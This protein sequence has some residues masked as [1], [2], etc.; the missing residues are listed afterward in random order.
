M[1]ETVIQFLKRFQT[2]RVTA[3]E[4]KKDIRSSRTQTLGYNLDYSSFYS[5]IWGNRGQFESYDEIGRELS[6][7]M[8]AKSGALPFIPIITSLTFWEIIDTVK[9]RIDRVNEYPFSDRKDFIFN[10]LSEIEE[11]LKSKGSVYLGRSEGSSQIFAAEISKLRAIAGSGIEKNIEK[12]EQ[13]IG[14]GGPVK[15]V[16]DI[17]PTAND[18]PPMR[19][20]DVNNLFEKMWRERTSKDRRDSG[21]KR[22]RYLVD[23]MNI[24]FSKRIT[25]LDDIDIDYVTKA[26]RKASFCPDV[27]RSPLVPY[28][29]MQACTLP[30]LR[31]E[32]EVLEFFDWMQSDCSRIIKA[33]ERRQQIDLEDM[34]LPLRMESFERD[35]YD[36]LHHAKFA[37]SQELHDQVSTFRNFLNSKDAEESVRNDQKK[38]KETLVALY[39]KSS[40]IVNDDLMTLGDFDLE[41]LIKQMRQN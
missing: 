28:Y 16:L 41:G 32:S 15:G 7:G 13:L 36:R 24:A 17:F 25:E 11:D 35:F 8:I 22:A 1:D 19:A 27:G 12:F 33:L 4:V 34:F 2:L 23:A 31:S 5:F 10:R 3:R 40:A 6:K 39:E 18:I 21:E 29:W 14:T 38:A 37:A 9:K 20:S 26:S 30:D